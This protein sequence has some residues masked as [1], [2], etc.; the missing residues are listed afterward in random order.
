MGSQGCPHSCRRCSS[1]G[2]LPAEQPLRN[3]L[4]ASCLDRR[5]WRSHR[6]T[7]AWDTISSRR[8]KENEMLERYYV[9]A[10]DRTGHPYIFSPYSQYRS[11]LNTTFDHGIVDCGYSILMKDKEYP[12]EFFEKYESVIR[13]LREVFPRS[14]IWYVP[15]DYPCERKILGFKE[16]LKERVEKTISNPLK[17]TKLDLDVEWLIPIQG[18]VLSDYIYCIDRYQEEGINLEKVGV[19][20]VCKRR[21][22]KPIITVLRGIK[23]KLPEAWIHAFGLTKRFLWETFD[24]I[25]S[26]DTASYNLGRLKYLNDPER[27]DNWNSHIF[28]F[29]QWK[30]DVDD[31]IRRYSLQSKISEFIVPPKE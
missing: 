1:L 27:P 5:S 19:G 8:E 14:R 16:S 30:K 20:T 13:E 9:Y 10:P 3:T 25:D 23:N 31:L 29:N 12:A 28:Q 21:R 15:P 17:F 4:L 11:L 26:F 6:R 7:C 2:A 24:Y 18:W 22:R